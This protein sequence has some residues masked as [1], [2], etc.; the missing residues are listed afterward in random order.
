MIARGPNVD[1]WS[2][3]KR[4]HAGGVNRSMPILNHMGDRGTGS[5]RGRARVLVIDDDESMCDLVAAALNARGLPTY[6][7]TDPERAIDAIEA[8]DVAVVISD[9]RMQAMTGIELCERILGTRPD[10]RVILLT[11]HGDMKAAVA[12]LRVRACD[13]FE[14]PPDMDALAAAVERA[15]ASLP[16]PPAR[17]AMPSDDGGSPAIADG[18]IGKCRSMRELAQIIDR[19]A[20]VDAT[21]LVRGESGTGKDLVARAIH[22]R[23]SRRAAPFIA[24]N[25][26]AIPHTL[27]EAE[28]F[29]HAKGAFTDARSAR[30]GLFEM[31][32]G[33]TLFL[34]E[35]ADL[36]L[37][38]Q[39][40]LLRALQERAIRPIGSTREVDIDVRLITATN[41]DLAG[42]VARRE[43]RA[44]LFYRLNVVE[45]LVP[46]LR[47]RGED[48]LL[49]AHQ[50]LEDCARS[51]RRD[52][53]GFTSA[54]AARLEGYAW[55][56]NVREL[57]NVIERAV[58]LT[59]G[60][61]LDVEDLPRH[62][63]RPDASKPLPQADAPVA[64]A[65]LAEIERQ[66]IRRVME[67]TGG[68]KSRAAQILGVDRRT[69]YRKSWDEEPPNAAPQVVAAA[70]VTAAL[71]ER[72]IE[73]R[74]R[75]VGTIRAAVERGDFEV[76]ARL[77]HNMNGNG[78]S[79]GFPEIS[80]IGARMEAA[81]EI[82]DAMQVHQEVVALEAWVLHSADVGDGQG[83]GAEAS[84]FV[85]PRPGGR[86]RGRPRGRRRNRAT[87]RVANPHRRG[88]DPWWRRH[89]PQL[90]RT[91][92]DRTGAPR[93]S[94]QR[95]GTGSHPRPGRRS[96][97]SSTS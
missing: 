22:A 60:A 17:P 59:R 45:I 89:R 40:K 74:T 38:L 10:I 25:C 42:A 56:G 91:R 86:D 79:Y 6:G 78:S 19:V 32:R 90:E 96:R 57:G 97:P 61:H 87:Q 47:E 80:G 13:F 67:A 34:D 85:H 5:T 4:S 54:C 72:F 3:E 1:T 62:F 66:H 24:I 94:A 63:R 20:A 18:L 52:V 64:L 41:A 55:P 36:H 84:R 95:S 46:P 71:R 68:N 75:D 8:S 12:A 92:T 26:A 50:F 49:L 44:D 81:A 28:L 23:G 58:A 16:L 27:L 33:G 7:E 82:Q 37:S 43:F 9:L 88:D 48:V 69:L 14:K 15:L 51:M 11:G 39:P 77:A 31:A 21:V 35:I 73:H 65:S 70:P 53:R 83:A 29:G 30:S 76:V 2:T 93:V